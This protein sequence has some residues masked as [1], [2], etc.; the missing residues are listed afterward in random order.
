ML[1]KD[2]SG[3]YIVDSA[4]RLDCNANSIQ[5]TIN[6]LITKNTLIYSTKFASCAPENVREVPI[7]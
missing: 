2:H 1:L 3:D 6:S 7:S 4:I 5:N